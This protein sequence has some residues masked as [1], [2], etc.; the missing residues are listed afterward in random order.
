MTVWGAWNSE[1]PKGWARIGSGPDLFVTVRVAGEKAGA[2]A[3]NLS[4]GYG[5]WEEIQRPR[6]D[7]FVE[8][9]GHKAMKLTV[10]LMFD[11][12]LADLNKEPEPPWGDSVERDIKV[13]EMMTRAQPN[14]NSPP[15]LIIQ[16]DVVPHGGKDWVIED[17][18]WAMD[19]V[20]RPTD[21]NRTRASCVVSFLEFLTVDLLL[22]SRRK[23]AKGKKIKTK[24]KKG[25]Y[26]VKEGDTTKKIARKELGSAAH[27]AEIAS[28]NNIRDGNALIVGER[29]LLP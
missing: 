8:W 22:Q 3:A 27:H 4:G 29:L 17:I 13:L 19:D 25:R 21:G 6:E 28:L 2:P 16:S 1:V 10:P 15:I 23:K 12:L 9:M 18:V 24:S 5:G 20:R 7:A 14:N 11:G 26:I